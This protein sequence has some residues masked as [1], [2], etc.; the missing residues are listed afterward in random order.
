M[1]D[2]SAKSSSGLSLN[3]TLMVGPTIQDSLVDICVRFRIYPVVFTGDVSKM[4]RMIAVSLDHTKFLRVFWRPNPS[5]P[6]MILELAT[7][8]YGTASAPYLATRTL[9]QLAQDEGRI[10]GQP[11]FW[12]T[13]ST[14]TMYCQEP[15]VWRKL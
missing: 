12:R 6:M 11:K 4:Y 14:S 8:T 3:D 1:F 9:K 13:T 10:Q 2:A 15:T 5:V 7:V